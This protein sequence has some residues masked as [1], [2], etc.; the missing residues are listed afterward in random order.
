MDAQLAFRFEDEVDQFAGELV[1][2]FLQLFPDPL[3][4]FGE[5]VAL[6]FAG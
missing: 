5:E 6:E 2:V 1:A 3:R 4:A